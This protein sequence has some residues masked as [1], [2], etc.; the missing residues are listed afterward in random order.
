MMRS[1]GISVNDGSI[2]KMGRVPEGGRY[3]VIEHMPDG[4]SRVLITNVS[5]SR[6][7]AVTVALND[8]KGK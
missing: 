8:T 1:S 7:S 6:A 3:E 2:F 4:K 5:I